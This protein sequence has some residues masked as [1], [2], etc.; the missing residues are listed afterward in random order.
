MEYISI[1]TIADKMTVDLSSFVDALFKAEVIDRKIKFFISDDIQYYDEAISFEENEDIPIVFGL[2]NLVTGR[3]PIL[4]TGV[5]AE[6]Y[7]ISIKCKIDD[8]DLALEI[9]DYYVRLQNEDKTFVLDGWTIYRNVEKPIFL[10]KVDNYKGNKYETMQ[11]SLRM[12]YFYNLGGVSNTSPTMVI[13]SVSVDHIALFY[14]N[15]KSML[16]NISF[17]SNSNDKLVTEELRVTFPIQTTNT[18]IMELLTAILNNSYNK[19]YSINY[20]VGGISKTTSYVLR[21]GEIQYTKDGTMLSFTCTF[22][23]SLPRISMTINGDSQLVVEYT[24]AREKEGVNVTSSSSGLAQIKKEYVTSA[25]SLSVML[26]DN[27]STIFNLIA[28]DIALGVKTPYTVVLPVGG[29]ERT[30]TMQL[31]GGSIVSN[32]TAN[33]TLSATFTEA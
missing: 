31:K 1:K 11:Y 28:N 29:V 4:N 19:T 12:T 6:D 17:G 10:G 16:P 30:F 18:K 21:V 22:F 3:M 13:D 24:L 33:L 9:L 20:N 25:L 15:S 26:V 5:Y 27:G 14:Q 32:E 8:R 2:L 7:Q 23:K